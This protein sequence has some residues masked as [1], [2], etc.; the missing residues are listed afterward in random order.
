M[1]GR[2]SHVGTH[3]S[4]SIF[5]DGIHAADTPPGAARAAAAVLAACSAAAGDLLYYAGD[6]RADAI[7]LSA[8]SGG[9]LNW[10]RFRAIFPRKLDVLASGTPV[11]RLAVHGHV[12]A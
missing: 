3:S 5:H 6:G 2:E 4:N 11:G 9:A 1:A 8:W 7:Q 10:R 12:D